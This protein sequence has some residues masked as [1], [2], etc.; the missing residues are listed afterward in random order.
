[1]KNLNFK[2][3]M[4]GKHRVEDM[5]HVGYID[6][7]EFEVCLY[8]KEG[9]H[10]PHFHVRDKTT[11]GQK[12]ETCIKISENRYFHHGSYDDRLNSGQRTALMEFLK[13]KPVG[14]YN[15]YDTYYELIAATWEFMNP[16][17][18]IELNQD[19]EGNIIIPDYTEIKEY[20]DKKQ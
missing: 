20:K 12:F 15:K 17:S 4:S 16:N 3:L 19:E 10:I 18:S 5:A 1:M 8:S 11:E 13:S 7:N 9:K 2:K 14:K 6:N